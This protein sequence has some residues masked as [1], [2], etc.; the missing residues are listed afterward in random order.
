MKVNPSIF[1]KKLMDYKNTE[2]T[3]LWLEKA[4]DMQVEVALLK[5]WLESMWTR[6]SKLTK[7]KSGDGAAEHTDRDK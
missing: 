3:R 1:N 4:D 2:K 5:T 7:A 6:Y